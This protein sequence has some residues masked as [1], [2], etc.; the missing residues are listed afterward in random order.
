MAFQTIEANL[1]RPG[2][3]YAT[4]RG[5]PSWLPVTPVDIHTVLDDDA[6][7]ARLEE[8]VGTVDLVCGGPP[9]QGFSIGGI[10]NGSDHRNRLPEQYL[11]FVRIV[12]PRF[13]LLENVEGMARRFISQPGQHPVSY[14]E[15]FEEELSRCGFTTRAC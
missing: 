13:V 8:M 5:W 15:W 3:P 1:L 10:R 7:R 12:K 9:C 4:G 11:E 6:M 14:A 2:A